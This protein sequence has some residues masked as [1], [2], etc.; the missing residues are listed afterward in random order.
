MDENLYDVVIIGSGI[1]G[2]AIAYKLSQKS[3]LKIAVIDKEQMPNMHQTGRNSGVIHSGIYYPKNSLKSKNCLDGYKQLLGFLK[4]FEI[5]HKITGKLI[6]AADESEYAELDKLYDNGVKLGLKV[7]YMD[8]EQIRQIDNNLVSKKGVFVEETGITDYKKVLKTFIDVSSKLGVKFMFSHAIKSV[9]NE[10]DSVILYTG[11]K[12]LKTR[13]LINCAGLQCDRVYKI[14]T[15]KD[16]P[17]T[18]LPFKGEYFNI[19]ASSYSSD[20]PI[21]PVPNPNFPFLGIHLTRMI[22][23][24]LNVGPNAVLSFDRE[25]YN[26]FKVNIKDSLKIITNKALFNVVR[27]YGKIVVSELLKYSNKVYFERSVKKYY[28][29]FSKKNITGYSC[30]IRAQATENGELL[31]DFRIEK[32]DNQIHV[33]NAPSPAATS[34]LA[35]ADTI[36]KT[37]EI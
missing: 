10:K 25:G 35:I 15:S 2:G 7:S 12:Y 33:L 37:M 6:V 16:S 22:D 13:Y 34:C 3:G 24:T 23:G 14:C 26:G 28:S 20:I 19:D 11:Q 9:S 18:I 27:K 31:S 36:I 17:V 32:I 30:G 8:A 29:N 5:P 4:K 21:Y 1:V